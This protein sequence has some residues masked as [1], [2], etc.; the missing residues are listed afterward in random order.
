MERPPW[1]SELTPWL[2]PPDMDRDEVVVCSVKE[3]EV[4][5]KEAMTLNGCPYGIVGRAGEL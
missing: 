1:G 4:K 5:M 3:G 2:L